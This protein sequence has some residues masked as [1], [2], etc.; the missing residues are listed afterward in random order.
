MAAKSSSEQEHTSTVSMYFPC[1]IIIHLWA[2]HLISFNL[3]VII[4]MDFPALVK[5]EIIS[6]NSSISWGVREAV[7]SSKIKMSAPRYKTFRIS[8]LCCMPT[9]MSSTLASTS[10]IKW[11]CSESS[12]ILFFAPFKSTVS[13]C[14]GSAPRII[15]S[16]TVKGGISIKC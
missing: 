12:R 16:A 10:T 6:I 11:Y 8:T 1:R 4:R 2:M 5:W 13:P 3:W 7:G 9:L 14:M 15:F